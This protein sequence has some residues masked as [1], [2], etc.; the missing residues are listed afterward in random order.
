MPAHGPDAYSARDRLEILKAA[1]DDVTASEPF[2]PSNDSVLPAV[3]ALRRTHQ[4]VTES[5]AYLTAQAS[6]LADAKLRLE[7]SQADKEDN[8]LLTRALQA[9]IQSL[10]DAD[11]T[12]DAM[13]PERAARQRIDELRARQKSYDAER[14]RLLRALKRFVDTRLGPLLAA[15]DQGGPVVG[16]MMDVDDATLEAGFTSTGRPKKAGPV[17]D[18]DAGQRRIDDMW[19]ASGTDA[20]GSRGR[21]RDESAAAKAANEM[22][23]LVE[24]LLNSLIESEGDASAAYV[25]LPRVS[26]AARFLVRSKV[27]MFH[28]KDS[29]RLR[30]V[31]FGRELDE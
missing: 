15:E 3:L 27:A 18:A 1:Y 17:K 29:R 30:L 25:E 8:A 14:T 19:G 26:A 4:T 10:R 9:R 21:S 23:S 13:T 2:L 12:D 28:P 22:R 31:D 7:A 24:D 5:R 16:D 20:G 11:D 6:S